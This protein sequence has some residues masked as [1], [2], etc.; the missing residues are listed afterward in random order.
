MLDKNTINKVTNALI[1][2]GKSSTPELEDRL[3]ICESVLGAYIPADRDL[4]SLQDADALTK[5]FGK[6]LFR[7]PDK[8]FKQ[9]RGV[10]IAL[11]H[12]LDALDERRRSLN[13]TVEALDRVKSELA[14]QQARIESFNALQEEFDHDKAALSNLTK[15]A[16]RLEARQD[17]Q[18]EEHGKIQKGIDDVNELIKQKQ[19][20]IDDQN[21]EIAKCETDFEELRRQF[22]DELTDG[23]VIEIIRLC[24]GMGLLAKANLDL[25]CEYVTD[26]ALC[27]RLKAAAL[28]TTERLKPLQEYEA[29]LDSAF[30][31]YRECLREIIRGLPQYAGTGGLIHTEAKQ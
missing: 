18:R 9:G 25:F 13:L 29:R 5:F 23:Q 1:E 12:I 14:M 10:I 7:A 20:F 22:N 8:L 26:H 27:E 16:A 31:G 24:S 11:N 6:Y 2:A 28:I 3:N 17:A 21:Q 30:A 15:E 19:A 4:E